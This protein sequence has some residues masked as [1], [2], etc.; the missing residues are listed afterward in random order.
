LVLDYA[1]GF[2]LLLGQLGS[3]H[4]KGLS[5]TTQFLSPV[6]LQPLLLFVLFIDILRALFHKSFIGKAALLT[7]GLFSLLLERLF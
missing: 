4:S 6:F 7:E 5:S 2:I 3:K 1:G